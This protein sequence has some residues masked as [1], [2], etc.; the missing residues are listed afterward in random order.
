MVSVAFITD[1]PRV[2]GSE[3]WLLTYLP[4]LPAHGIIPSLHILKHKKL[5]DLAE[6]LVEKGIEVVRHEYFSVSKIQESNA[7]LFAVQAWRGDLYNRLLPK[8]VG[9]TIAIV[10]DQLDFHYPLGLRKLYNLAYRL[11]KAKSLQNA[12]AVLTVSKWG[13]GFLQ[14]HCGITR[15]LAVTNGVDTERFIPAPQRR[16]QLRVQFEFRR[17]TILVPGRMAPEKNHI[18][19]LMAAKLV[20]AA[21]FVFLGDVDSVTGRWIQHLAKYWRLENTRFLGKRWDMPALYQAADAILQPTLAENQSL[22]TLE[23]MSSG[24]PVITSDIPAQAELIRN[25][26]EG[27]LVTPNPKAIALAIQRLMDNESWAK[28]LGKAGRQRVLTEHKLSD[29]VAT[30]ARTLLET[31]FSF[32]S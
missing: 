30:L 28:E 18:A 16:V 27:L 32:P 20:P 8:L 23:A 15:V 7:G 21:D 9:N 22:V 2:A 31:T 3:I 14:T 5:D 13:A 26:H 10:H 11:T 19:A 29:S 25:E 24:L 1:A 6:K 17:F 4:L 12:H